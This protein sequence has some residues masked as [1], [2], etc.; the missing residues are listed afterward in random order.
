M[1][2]SRK[3]IGIEQADNGGFLISGPDRALIAACSTFEE[4][5]GVVRR[6]FD[7]EPVL[8]AA[9]ERLYPTINA[10]SEDKAA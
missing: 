4:M 1:T 3:W 7:S 10:D 9:M 2:A 8:A 6:E 5:L